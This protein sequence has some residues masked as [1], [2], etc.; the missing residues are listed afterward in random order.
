MM[1]GKNRIKI[2]IETYLMNPNELHGVAEQITEMCKN[3]IFQ[4]NGDK[5]SFQTIALIE[6]E[7]EEKIIDGK[8]VHVYQS[9][10][11]K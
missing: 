2:E 3:G 1:Q 4:Y 10:M 8:V 6:P 11:N 7:Y 5:F 9:K